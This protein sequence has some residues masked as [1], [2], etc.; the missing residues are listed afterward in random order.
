MTLDQRRALVDTI[1][2]HL[3]EMGV[4]ELRVVELLARRL[5]MG[6]KLYG[7]L[8]LADDPRDWLKEAIEEAADLPIYLA[9]WLL[10]RLMAMAAR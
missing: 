3:A 10:K 4:D 6:A 7:V 9:L 5:G 1:S 2:G 8:N